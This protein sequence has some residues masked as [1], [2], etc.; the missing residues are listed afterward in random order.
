MIYCFSGPTCQHD[1]RVVLDL[2]FDSSLTW[3]KLLFGLF[4]GL[5]ELKGNSGEEL[6]AP[7]CI[8]LKMHASCDVKCQARILGFSEGNPMGDESQSPCANHATC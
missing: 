2:D 1:A 6:Q 8:V 7:S 3:T 4:E 5:Q